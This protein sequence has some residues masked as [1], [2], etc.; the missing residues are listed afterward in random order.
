MQR[1]HILSTCALLMCSSTPVAGLDLKNAVVVM[2]P[3]VTLQEKT[4]VAVLVDEVQKR[5]Q[6]KL[7]V[8]NTMPGSGPAIVVGTSAKLAGIAGAPL[9][10]LADVPRGDEGFRVQAVD[11]SVVVAGNDARGML[12]GVG[13]LLRNMR[14]ERGH[15]LEVEDT[16]RIA[17]APRLRLR[18]HQLGYRPK[19]NACDGFTVDMFDQYIRDL[20]IFGTNSIE[21]IPPR[22]DDADDSPHFPLP[23]IE[24]MEEVSRICDR[25]WLDVWIWYPAM[26][27]DYSDPATVEFA[28]KEWE[29]VY[30][31][32]PRIDYIFVPGGDPGHT[33]P[34][35]LFALLEKQT[36][37]LRRYHPKAQ[38]WMSRRASAKSGLKSS[39]RS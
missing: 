5:T 14:M 15:V 33:Q 37:L 12:F 28:L 17:T 4:S 16:L 20:A 38:M 1:T 34:K 23:K 18:G 30:R 26:D 29:Q 36:A 6:M 35:H 3:N 21:L 22:S 24:M 9:G 7:A 8:Q 39:T 10:R 31:R 27:R 2:P 25:Y 32:L 19:V 13:Y 11:G